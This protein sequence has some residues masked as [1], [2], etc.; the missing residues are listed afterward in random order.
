MYVNFRP[1]FHDEMPEWEEAISSVEALVS[2][3]VS[4]PSA[5]GSPNVPFGSFHR[6]AAAPPVPPGLGIPHH[7]HP[8]PSVPYSLTSGHAV[9]G[10]HTPPTV[11]L[12]L[13]PLRPPTRPASGQSGK[14]MPSAASGSEAKKTVQALAVE[15]G[16]SKDIASQAS[17]SQ[18]RVVLEEE[19]FPALNTPA[20]SSATAAAA[21][22]SKSKLAAA[23]KATSLPSSKKGAE[24]SAKPSTGKPPSEPNLLLP[25]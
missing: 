22:T 14:K 21:P 13:T 3:D 4:F 6:T 5:T 2:E 1:S 12:P 25:F 10:P 18:S 9:G 8:S 11:A 16:L 17:K 24:K 23:A 19:D 15:T 20:K 7:G